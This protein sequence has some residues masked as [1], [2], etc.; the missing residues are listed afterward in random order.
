MWTATIE[1]SIWQNK[2][3]FTQPDNTALQSQK[4]VSAHLYRKQILPITKYSRINAGDYVDANLA[5]AV[6]GS[7][8]YSTHLSSVEIARNVFFSTNKK[9]S[10]TRCFG[11]VRWLFKA[12]TIE[13]YALSKYKLLLSLRYKLDL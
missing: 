4:A 3:I 6:L 12:T 10:S 1:C 11:C 9:Y 8:K 13:S 7:V 2:N 5:V